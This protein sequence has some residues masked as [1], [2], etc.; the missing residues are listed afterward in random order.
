MS[1]KI[2]CFKLSNFKNM[3]APGSAIVW[4]G[5]Q[6]CKQLWKHVKQPIYTTNKFIRVSFR[7]YFFVSR[8]M[9]PFQKFFENFFGKK[10]FV[11]LFKKFVSFI[12]IFQNIF[13]NCFLKLFFRK[14]NFLKI[15]FEIFVGTF[16][17]FFQNLFQKIFWFF[18]EQIRPHQPLSTPL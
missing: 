13:S 16:F 1:L 14:W 10:F 7:K 12:R 11:N 3:Y 2:D 9:F 4:P 6:S 15:F 18:F 8:K 17:N 5:S